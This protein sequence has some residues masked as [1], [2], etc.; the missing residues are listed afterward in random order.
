MNAAQLLTELKGRGVM[1]EAKG[2]RLVIDA[3]KGTVTPE[4]R[5]VLAERKA[6]LLTLLKV[7]DAEIAWRVAA[8]LPQ[9]PATGLIPF[10][11]ARNEFKWKRGLCHS[12]GDSLSVNE[13]YVCGP[14]SRAIHQALGLAMN[15]K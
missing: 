3:P 7:N 6:E 12:C 4:L 2:D 10:L 13:N 11:V 1:L 14:C 5:E 8:I 9:I 15:R